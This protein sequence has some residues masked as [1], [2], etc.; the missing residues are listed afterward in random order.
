MTSYLLTLKGDLQELLDK[1]QE[2]SDN[3]AIGISTSKE[4]QDL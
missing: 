1:V 4:V 2:G 3:A